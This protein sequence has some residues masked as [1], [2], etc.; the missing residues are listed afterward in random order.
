MEHRCCTRYQTPLI[1]RRHAVLLYPSLPPG[2]CRSISSQLRPWQGYEE[3]LEPAPLN[4]ALKQTPRKPP[5]PMVPTWI[6][7]GDPATPGWRLSA[8]SAH[9]PWPPSS[10]C[11]RDGAVG[12]VP[13]VDI[14]ELGGSRTVGCWIRRL[15]V[16]LRLW[17]VGSVRGRG[18]GCE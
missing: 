3:D 17:P 2:I 8:C 1:P 11:C 14:C 10:R 4:P 9:L 6:K 16:I 18:P 12:G 7:H 13:V 5:T 15:P